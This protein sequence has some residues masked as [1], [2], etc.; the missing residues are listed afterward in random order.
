MVTLNHNQFRFSKNH[1]LVQLY[2]KN[3][4]IWVYLEHFIRASDVSF[5]LSLSL[6][7]SFFLIENLSAEKWNIFCC[8]GKQGCQQLKPPQWWAAEPW[9][10]P[11]R[12]EHPLSSSHQTAATPYGEPQGSSGFENSY[13]PQIAEVHIKGMISVHPDSS[14]FSNI[15]KH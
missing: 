13:W 3:R 7:L 8:I 2:G 11:G 5:S 4:N 1:D 6:A 15:E 14:I 9:G 12:K 10:D